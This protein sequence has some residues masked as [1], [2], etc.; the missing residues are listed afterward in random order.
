MTATV[1]VTRHAGKAGRTTIES[2]TAMV[3][4]PG[5]PDQTVTFVG[6]DGG[7]IVRLWSGS[8]ARVIADPYRFGRFGTDWVRRYYGSGVTA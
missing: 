2:V 5:Q 3:T 8:T 7:K 1:T 6:E 4:Y